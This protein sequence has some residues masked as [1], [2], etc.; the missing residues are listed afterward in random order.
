M[1]LEADDD[2]LDFPVVYA[3]ARDGI[4]KASMEDDSTDMTALF[5]V[6]IK[7]I[8]APQGDIDGPLQFMVTTLDYDDFVGKLQ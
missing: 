7:E 4:A 8:P 1:E 5:D 2:Q 3:S 6:L